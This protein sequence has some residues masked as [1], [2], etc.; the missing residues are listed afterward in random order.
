MKI[1]WLAHRDPLNPNAG[2]AEKIIYEVGKRLVSNAVESEEVSDV[3]KKYGIKE[4]RKKTKILE[5]RDIV[6]REAKGKYVLL[7]DDTRYIRLHDL[8]IICNRLETTLKKIII[9]PEFQTGSQFGDSILRNN[10]KNYVSA[11][12]E[13]D[14]IKR[15]FILPRLYEKNLLSLSMNQIKKDIP[16]NIFFNLEA[17]D[18]ELIYLQAYRIHNEIGLFEGVYI[19]HL[20][21]GG[22]IYE[23]KK[24]FKYGFN[25]RILKQ[26]S[27]YKKLG[28][29]KGRMRIPRNK[30]DLYSSLFIVVYRGIPFTLGFIYKFMEERKIYQFWLD[31]FKRI[32]GKN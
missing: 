3:I 19:Y 2:G 13:Y 20:P 30:K 21:T 4:I 26:I 1:L 15:R 10:L 27:P 32:K 11:S 31:S 7:M 8:R 28:N 24:F 25:T 9:I 5:S 12:K 6:I 22:A 14:P 17:L 23:F 16:T 18:L 29:L